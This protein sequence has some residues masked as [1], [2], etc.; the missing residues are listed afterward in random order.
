MKPQITSKWEGTWKDD[1]GRYMRIQWNETPE[2]L[3]RGFFIQ[4]SGDLDVQLY[5]DGN[6]TLD[7]SKLMERKRGDEKGWPL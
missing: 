5:K 1:R 4:G 6:H 7:G 3:A 2:G